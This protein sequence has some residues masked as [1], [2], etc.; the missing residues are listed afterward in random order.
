MGHRI[1]HTGFNY[2][3]ILFICHINKLCYYVTVGII[4]PDINSVKIITKAI[5]QA[6]TRI[7]REY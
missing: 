2:N 1:I 7:L 3:Y 4:Q 5:V 6:K